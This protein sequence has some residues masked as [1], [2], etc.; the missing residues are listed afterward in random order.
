[1]EGLS[2]KRISAKNG[3]AAHYCSQE[4][5]NT[6]NNDGDRKAPITT[7]KDTTTARTRTHKKTNHE[8]NEK[9]DNRTHSWR[10][11]ARRKTTPNDWT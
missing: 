2:A 5:W 8:D 11:A 7:S 1:M 6:I 4:Q 3:L 10:T 9:K